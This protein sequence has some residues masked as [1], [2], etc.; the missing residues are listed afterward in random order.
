MSQGS[1]TT[2]H[3]D[4]KWHNVIEGTDQV[5]EPFDRMD[6]AIEEGRGMA[7]DLGVDHVVKNID[8]SVL[9]HTSP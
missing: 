7:R 3:N 4:G 2:L 9:E 8:G 1:I 6:D 5:S